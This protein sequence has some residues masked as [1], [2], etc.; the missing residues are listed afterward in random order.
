MWFFIVAVFK[1]TLGC[2]FVGLF[3]NLE[4]VETAGSDYGEKSKFALAVLDEKKIR[5]YDLAQL[6]SDKDVKLT[7]FK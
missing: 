4:T 3:S 6:E 7:P 2:N 5:F 1:N